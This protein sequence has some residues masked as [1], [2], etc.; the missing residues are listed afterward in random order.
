MI[1]RRPWIGR[2]LLPRRRSVPGRL[3]VRAPE[4]GPLRWPHRAATTVGEE[5]CP[6]ATT[7]P[8][9]QRALR[10]RE[11]PEADP[12]TVEALGAG[13]ECI[14]AE[15]ARLADCH[16]HQFGG[17]VEGAGVRPDD[18]TVEQRRL[19]VAFGQQ[20]ADEAGA[21]DPRFPSQPGSRRRGTGRRGEGEQLL[22][23]RQIAKPIVSC[24]IADVW[25]PSGRGSD[26]AYRSRQIP[27]PTRGASGPTSCQAPCPSETWRSGTSRRAWPES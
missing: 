1:R 15:R 13:E 7:E 2:P 23:R 11:E 21:V 5:S 9:R 19:T 25:Q 22:R 16:G 24:P 4:R 27:R 20:G 12:D 14:N 26:R 3:I 8:S 6:G 17:Y 10:H 18:W